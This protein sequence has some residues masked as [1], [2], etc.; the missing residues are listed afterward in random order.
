MLTPERANIITKILEADVTRANS[1]LK[2]EPREALAEL[3]ALDNDFTMDEIISYGEAV[4]T[5]IAYDK[6]TKKQVK[7]EVKTAIKQGDLGDEFEVEVEVELDEATL[8]RVAK[9]VNKYLT[10]W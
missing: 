3:N 4:K 10:N 1:L 2:L 7:K 8:K 9:S 5:A 6:S